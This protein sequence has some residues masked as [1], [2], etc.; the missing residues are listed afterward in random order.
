MFEVQGLGFVAF[1]FFWGWVLHSVGGLRVEDIG[2]TIQ[3]LGL[4][5]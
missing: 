4:R 3:G 2:C 1:G 5:T